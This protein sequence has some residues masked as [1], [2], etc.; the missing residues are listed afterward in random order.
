MCL[1]AASSVS[2]D[3]E[4]VKD[5]SSFSFGTVFN[6]R[7]SE[8]HTFTEFSGFVQ[9][10]GNAKFDINL[11]SVKTGIEKRDQRIHKILFTRPMA[12]SYW[13]R[14]D[15]RHIESLP[16][17]EPRE[18]VLRGSFIFNKRPTP[19]PLRVKVTRMKAGRFRVESIGSNV[20]DASTL[21]L[22][23]KIERLRAAAGLWDISPMVSLEF[24]LVFKPYVHEDTSVTPEVVTNP[25]SALPSMVEERQSVGTR[26]IITYKVTSKMWGSEGQGLETSNEVLE[27]IHKAFS[28]WEEASLGSLDLV[29]AGFSQPS[30]DSRAQVPYDGSIHL[31]L[32]GRNNFH[33]ERGNANYRGTIPKEYKRGTIFLDKDPNALTVRVIAHEIGH[34]LG[35]A[36]GASSASIMFSGPWARTGYVVDKL[37]EQDSANLRALWSPDSTG[38]YTIAGEVQTLHYHKM[39]FVFAVD[40][41]SGHTYSTRSDHNGKFTLAL[42]KPGNYF[43]VAKAVEVSQDIKALDTQKFIPQSPGWYVRNGL[44]S[45]DYSRATALKLTVDD[46]DIENINLKMIDKS[47]PFRLTRA[48][49]VT[50]SNGLGILSP[51]DKITLALHQVRN[52]SKVSGF[53]KSPDYYFQPVIRSADGGT[54]VTLVTDAGATEGER[55]VLVRD[56]NGRSNIGLIGIYLGR[57]R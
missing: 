20:L 32:Y 43:L 31:V 13:V 50:G 47:A 27:R 48:Q 55:L 42:L 45:P 24:K 51:G 8:K 30:Y 46:P 41:I 37:T 52:L 22:A 10:G 57:K 49:A 4:M 5:E 36:H 28:L 9:K 38:L 17:N 11:L 12:A 23:D 35:I 44:S 6:E 18:L 15:T 2:A 16:I 1:V 34:A 33:G 54:Q 3:W 56:R 21:G 14:V 29:Y 25:V 19:V 53:G 40:V 26:R 7:E 39:A